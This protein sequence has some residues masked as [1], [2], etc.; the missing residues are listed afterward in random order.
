MGKLISVSLIALLLATACATTAQPLWYKPGADQQ[1]FAKDKYECMQ[2]SKTSWS[3]GGTGIIGIA[4]MAGA[5]ADAQSKANATF[6][7]CMEARGWVM[8]AQENVDNAKTE[9]SNASSKQPKNIG[10]EVAR[11]NEQVHE[12]IQRIESNPTYQSV[13]QHINIDGNKSPSLEQ[14][15]DAST[16]TDEEIQIIMSIHKDMVE[17]REQFLQDYGKIF[18]KVIPLMRELYSSSDL[19]F[20]DLVERKITWG[21]ANKQRAELR[22]EFTL[23]LKDQGK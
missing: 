17:C 4:A 10:T 20:A 12:C 9:V 1:D 13:V 21:D 14:L 6:K 16:P 8:Q 11:I 5:A 18:P 7:M 3:G 23:K 15:T 19:I 2:D 22:K